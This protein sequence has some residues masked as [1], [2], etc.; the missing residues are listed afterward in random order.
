ME[1]K[2]ILKPEGS[3]VAGLAT[4]AAVYGIYQLEVGSV[5]QAQA[6]K[7]NHPA[8][9]T[10]RK[11]AGYT[12]LV[13]VAGLTL[14]TR[15]GNV[16]IL[17]AGTIVAMELSYRHAIMAHPETGRI[18]PPG[19]TVYSPPELQVVPEEASTGTDDYYGR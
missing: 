3:V 15:D 10:S 14:I 2:S 5:S 8:N 4:V 11:K 9:E 17:G 6:T 12:A 18:M 1:I 16:G 7:P 19:G 13:L